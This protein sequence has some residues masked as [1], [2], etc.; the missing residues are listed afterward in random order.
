MEANQTTKTFKH[1]KG[2]LQIHREQRHGIATI[3]NPGLECLIW[4][5]SCRLGSVVLSNFQSMQEQILLPEDALA[6]PLPILNTILTTEICFFLPLVSSS[7][8]PPCPSSARRAP[9][10]AP[11]AGSVGQPSGPASGSASTAPSPVPKY[12]E[13]RRVKHC[14][15]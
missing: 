11:A 14:E 8:L 15:I 7:P 13:S 4:P 10:P 1:S 3:P 2:I 5:P 12:R 9:C 6:I